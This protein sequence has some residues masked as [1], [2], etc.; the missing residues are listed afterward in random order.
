M[1]QYQSLH[2]HPNGTFSNVQGSPCTQ[3]Y[4]IKTVSNIL[5]SF[6]WT[7][8]LQILRSPYISSFVF[9][10]W[11]SFLFGSK[12]RFPESAVTSAQNLYQR[13]S[14]N[15][16]LLLSIFLLLIRVLL[17]SICSESGGRRREFQV[18]ICKIT[19]SSAKNLRRMYLPQETVCVS[20]V[21]CL[22]KSNTHTTLQKCCKDKRIEEPWVGDV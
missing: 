3:L 7:K 6:Y 9:F 1:Y 21:I 2:Y 19:N 4:D 16:L 12:S 5:M 10:Q 14:T 22:R 8:A 11:L 20:P 15:V 13:L 18:P 17:S